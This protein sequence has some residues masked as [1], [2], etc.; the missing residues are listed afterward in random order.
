MGEVDPEERNG[1]ARERERRGK[2]DSKWNNAKGS[3][4]M[5]AARAICRAFSESGESGAHACS[6]VVA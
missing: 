3:K 1:R 2:S 6:D 5:M 4:E